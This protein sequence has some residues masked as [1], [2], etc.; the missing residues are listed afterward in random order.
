MIS[1]WTR[2][3]A[4]SEVVEIFQS[5]GIAAGIVQDAAALFSDPQ[6]KARDFLLDLPDIGPL[7]DA[8]PLR[9]SEISASY[10][11]AAPNPGAD[12]DY[13]YGELLGLSPEERRLLQSLHVI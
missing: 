7:V 9:L 10:R 6:L 3:R 8:S 13:V 1:A 4:A 11:R 5:S 2:S 12:N